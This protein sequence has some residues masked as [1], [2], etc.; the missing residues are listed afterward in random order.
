MNDDIIDYIDLCGLLGSYTDLVQGSGGN[1]SVK[2]SDTLCV[3]SSGRRLADTKEN[4]GYTL[5]SIEKLLQFKGQIDL[6]GAILE[7]GEPN[8]RP[9]MEVWFHLLPKKWVVHLH[10]TFLLGKLCS[11]SWTSIITSFIHGHVP[12]R[13]P[14]IDLATAIE[15]IYSGQ[16]VLFLQNHGIL[17]AVDTVQEVYEILDTLWTEHT[18]PMKPSLHIQAVA[19]LQQKLRTLSGQIYKIKPYTRTNTTGFNERLFLPI[20][21]DI[22]LFLKQYPLVQETK[23]ESLEQL[24]L[25]YKKKIQTYP[26]VIQVLGRT[27]LAGQSYLHCCF[28]E[29]ILESY[30]QILGTSNPNELT[31]FSESEQESLK[32]SPQEKHRLQIL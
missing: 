6:Q 30:I 8:S 23:N 12:Y 2:N 22:S 31:L 9:S 4:Y 25:D 28:I 29:E 11:K 1:I 15:E 5:C 16:K 14:G 17:I 32:D 10:P 26:A 19:S 20:T 3:K 21:P 24:L 27:F 18:Q 13:T 7:G